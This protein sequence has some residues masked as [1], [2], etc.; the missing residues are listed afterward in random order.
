MI[1]FVPEQWPLASPSTVYL[2]CQLP[3][4]PDGC[5]AWNCSVVS[6]DAT[7]GTAS[8]AIAPATRISLLDMRIPRNSWVLCV[9]GSCTHN[10]TA[11]PRR[12]GDS[13]RSAGG[14]G[15]SS[16]VIRGPRG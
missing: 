2:W 7:D 8:A 6:A 10:D 9:G 5:V 3:P 11:C 4:A 15:A 14:F 1:T 13:P 16:V 12:Y